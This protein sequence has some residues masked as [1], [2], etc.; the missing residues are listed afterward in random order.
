MRQRVVAREVG[1]LFRRFALFGDIR[2][3]TAETLVAAAV[4]DDRRARKLPPALLPADRDL[5]F[6]IGEI[7]APFE[8]V[9]QVVQA[10]RKAS[11]LP[12]IARNQLEER[13]PFDFRRFASEGK[14]KTR[15]D[16]PEPAAGIDL[17]QPVGLT[18]LEFA[19]QHRDHFALFLHRRFCQPHRYRYARA[20]DH[21]EHGE[22]RGQDNHGRKDRVEIDQAGDEAAD[23]CRKREGYRTERRAIAAGAAGQNQHCR[24]RP[25][26]QGIAELAIDRAQDE[27]DRPHRALRGSR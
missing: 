23:T 11:G 2:P 17:P 7:L 10:L 6:E 27:T 14:G 16:G 22:Q 13:P 18:F 19:Q 15:R 3:D 25:G 12:A 9:G 8:L 1:D 26:Q 20:F 5:D 21:A 4:I 24:D